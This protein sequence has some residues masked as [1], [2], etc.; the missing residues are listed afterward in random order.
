MPREELVLALE[1]FLDALAGRGGS[2]VVAAKVEPGLFLQIGEF[3]HE[4]FVLRPHMAIDRTRPHPRA[5]GDGA[6]GRRI[7]PALLKQR[8]GRLSNPGAAART[9]QQA[10]VVGSV[11]FAGGRYSTGSAR[12]HLCEQDRIDLERSAIGRME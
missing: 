6:E 3:E 1:E 12:L 4:E 11:I 2:G 9:A 5:R 7:E 8:A 10:S